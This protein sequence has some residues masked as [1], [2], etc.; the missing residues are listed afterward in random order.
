[1]GQ[2]EG[3]ILKMPSLRLGISKESDVAE[4]NRRKNKFLELIQLGEMAQ[5]GQLSARVRKAGVDEI[6]S[7]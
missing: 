7:E 6:A 3:R 1:M 2:G 4:L 5:W